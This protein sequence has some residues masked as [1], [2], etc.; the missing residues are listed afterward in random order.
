MAEKI[1]EDYE[2]INIGN[3]KSITLSDLITLIE[4]TV[5]KKAIID[6]LEEQP[7]DVSQT[8]AEISKAKNI[9]NWQPQT[10]ISDGMEEFVNWVKM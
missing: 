8:W 3:H 2:I 10:D 9:L 6:R 7:G 1:Y 4:K 5:N